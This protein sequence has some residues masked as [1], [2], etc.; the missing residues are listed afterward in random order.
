MK[1]INVFVLA[2]FG[3]GAFAE[4]SSAPKINIEKKGNFT[5]ME[6]EG[7]LKSGQDIGCLHMKEIKNSYTAADLYKGTVECIKKNRFEEAAEMYLTGGIYGRFDAA[8][9]SDKTA[10][11]G[12]QVLQINNFSGLDLE[13]RQKLS[14]EFQALAGNE[15]GKLKPFCKEI[16][17]IGYPKYYPEYLILHGINAF[18]GSP[19]ENALDKNFDADKTWNELL[20]KGIHCEEG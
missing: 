16:K 4:E 2:L 9:I 3:V 10:G 19:N 11:Q 13:L 20:T 1:I 6:V 12:I 18:N 5:H 15:N 8:R 17:S 14:T 7:N